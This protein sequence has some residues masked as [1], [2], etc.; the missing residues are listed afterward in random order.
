MTLGPFGALF[1]LEVAVHRNKSVSAHNFAM[2]PRNDVP[3]SSFLMEKK[4]MTTFDASA[5]IPIFV[6]E[7]LPGDTFNVQATLFARLSTPIL[8]IMDNLIL[9]SFFFFVPNRLT[10]SNWKK[11]MGEQDAPGDSISFQIPQ[12]VCPV[13]GWTIGS[14][15]DY[16]GLPTVGQVGGANTVTHSCLPMRAYALI[17]NAWFRDEN[18]CAP[19][20]VSTGDGPDVPAAWGN[21]TPRGK[22][23]DYFTSCLPFVQKGVAVQIPV[24]GNATVKTSAA[25]L[26]T[27][28]G[29]YSPM[30]LRT[31]GGGVPLTGGFNMRSAGGAGGGMNESTVANATGANSVIPTNLYADLTTGTIGTINQLRQSVAIQQ[32]LERDARGG[33]RYTE[34]LQSQFG[35]TPQDARLQRPEYLG[36]GSTPVNISEIPQTSATGLTGA[37]TPLGSLA[38]KGTLVGHG[39]GFTSSFAEHGY[40]LGIIAVRADLTYQQGLRR[41]WSRLT[42]YDF[43]TP[44]FANLGEQS[45][46]N[47][48]IFCDGGANDALVFGYLPRWDEYRFNPSEITG[49]FRS[50]A[51]ATIDIWHLAQK[52]AAVPTLNTT[53]IQ[54]AVPL[55][56]VL[57][58][59]AAANGKQ[60]IL[61]AF[62]RIKAA[63]PLPMYSNPGLD[64]L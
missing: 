22:R 18:L 4:Y 10:W 29:P 14:I 27:G 25:E 30:A 11:F 15:A 12:T 50:T 20:G 39:H 42:R 33:T 21:P 32:L 23:F 36:G 24:S 64:R 58:V 51:A 43:Y 31:S 44:V 38:A 26:I 49:L 52:F 61:D 54:E 2:V 28:G 19:Y 46:L 56:R 8:P 9:E 5:L 48:E 62:F 63:R 35:V 59:G 40:V 41:H 13:G 1:S 60:F 45:V 55:S 57:A 37:T 53:F 17:Y 3:R 6:E 47:K 34:I 7:V 16:M